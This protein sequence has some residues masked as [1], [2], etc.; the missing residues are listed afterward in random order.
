M[1]E[2]FSILSLLSIKMACRSLK[3]IFRN[4]TKI[5]MPLGFLVAAF[6]HISTSTFLRRTIS[7][8]DPHISYSNNSTDDYQPIAM[9]NVN[10]SISDGIEFAETPVFAITDKSLTNQTKRPVMHTFYEPIIGGCCGMTQEGH[11]RLLRA[12]ENA[13]QEQGWDTKII[14][15]DDAKQHPDFRIVSRQMNKPPMYISVY[16]RYC[17]LRWL[18]MASHSVGGGWMSDYDV[19]PLNFHPDDGI[20]LAKAHNGTFHTFARHTPCLIHASRKE[21][22]RV[23]HLMMDKVEERPDWARS[24]M[25]A[26]EQLTSSLSKNE[27][28]FWDLETIGKFP[29]VIDPDS[30][31]RV[32]DCRLSE[33]TEIKALHLSHKGVE[34]SLKEGLFPLSTDEVPNAAIAIEK[35]GEAAYTFMQEF[36]RECMSR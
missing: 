7:I 15:L 36:K 24:D 31:K 33:K 10:N 30:G 19:F 26:L 23:I 25:L 12:W 11:E 17:F 9:G 4:E 2:H 16:N 14:N 18:A 21:W 5:W 8:R 13:W 20:R 35:R 22:D 29:Y 27:R 34:V 32:I 3:S 28:T 1:I 6:I